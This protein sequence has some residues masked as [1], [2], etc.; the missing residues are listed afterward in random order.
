[1][2]YEIAE[3]SSGRAALDA[4]RLREE[5]LLALWEQ[6]L[7]ENTQPERVLVKVYMP[8]VTDFNRDF[9]PLRDLVYAPPLD[10]VLREGD[11][12]LCPPSYRHPKPFEGIVIDLDGSKH[13]Y[14]GPVKRLIRKI[15]NGD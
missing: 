6:E 11:R 8:W 9:D 15:E 7:L 10:T 2:A 13:P 3:G 5:E 12:V 4:S 1:M 14:K